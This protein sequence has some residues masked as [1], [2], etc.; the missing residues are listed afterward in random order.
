MPALDV[1][2]QSAELADVRIETN[3][4]V[5]RRPSLADVDRVTDLAGAYEVSKWLTRVPWPYQRSHAVAWIESAA[6]ADAS[7][8]TFFMDDGSGAIG[9]VGLANWRETPSIGYWL[10]QPYWGRGLMSEAVDAVLGFAFDRLGASEVR[11]SV[12]DHNHAS[13]RLQ[14]KFGFRETGRDLQMSLARGNEVPGTTTVLSRDDY[15]TFREPVVD[16]TLIVDDF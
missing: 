12:F 5:L 7:E 1:N 13:L 10:G 4:L 14:Q 3:R 8:L 15:G 9:A 11:S 6:A 16:H 2:A